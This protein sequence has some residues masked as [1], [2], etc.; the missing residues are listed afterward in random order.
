[1]KG[2]TVSGFVPSAYGAEFLVF[3]NTDTALNLDE[4]TGNYLRIQGVSFTQN[5]ARDLTV[6]D[7]FNSISDFSDPDIKEDGTIISPIRQQQRYLNIKNSRLTYGR[8]EFVIESAYIQSQDDA[9]DLMAWMI[10]KTMRPRKSVGMIL[11]SM[12]TIQLG[13]IVTIDYTST[14]SIEQISLDDTR[15]VVY[16]IEYQR[17]DLGPVMTVYLSEVL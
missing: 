10:D 4:T 16:N 2:Y 1:M 13:D 14:D 7:Y 11:F 6:D 3:N 8:K 15:F 9:N 5:V 17:N 12:P